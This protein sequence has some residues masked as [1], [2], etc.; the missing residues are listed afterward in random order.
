MGWILM[1]PADDPESQHA[2][3]VLLNTGECVFNLC[4]NGARLRPITFGPRA[5][6]EMEK[7]LY[8]FLGEVASGCWV[9]SQNKRFFMGMFFLLDV[10]LFSSQRS[11]GIQIKYLLHL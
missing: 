2:A 6:I 8:S 10:Q 4:K 7:K 3:Q 11:V 5:C 1:Q 9:I